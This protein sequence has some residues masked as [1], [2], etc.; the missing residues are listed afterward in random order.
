MT[1]DVVLEA[2]DVSVH[3]DGLR[4]VEGMQI[5]LREGRVTGLMGPNG[6]G[7]TT[8]FNTLSGH[9]RVDSGRVVLRGRDVTSLSPDARARLGIARTFQ[10][11]GLSE[12]LTVL[13]NVVLGVDHAG[14]IAKRRVSRRRAREVAWSWVERLELTD[15]ADR[16]G[17]DLGA[18]LR[19]KAEIARTLAAGAQIMLLDEPAAGLSGAEREELSAIL[20]TIAAEG[21]AILVT[22]HSTDFLFSSVDEVVVMNFGKRLAAGTP[23]E[24]QKDPEVIK[25]YL[26]GGS[27]G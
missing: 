11:G 10:L 2:T 8:F 20:R 14:R 22:D 23:G 6:A 16:I 24:V 5:H 26:G 27:H 19:R 17:G 7:K 21:K 15:V 9:Q 1:A 4:A 3:F 12:D 13:E 18:G 25:A